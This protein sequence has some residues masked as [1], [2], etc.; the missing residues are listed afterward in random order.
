MSVLWGEQLSESDASYFQLQVIT[1][2]KPCSTHERC[3]TCTNGVCIGT[4]QCILSYTSKPPNIPKCASVYLHT[5]S[6]LLSRL[7]SALSNAQHPQSQGPW[8]YITAIAAW[9]YVY[10]TGLLDW[11]TGLNFWP[12]HLANSKIQWCLKLYSVFTEVLTKV[13]ISCSIQT[14]WLATTMAFQKWEILPWRTSCMRKINHFMGWQ[15]YLI[16]LCG[17]LIK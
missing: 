10:W 3:T 1:V 6:V 7:L 14:G 13:W 9:E 16:R 15:C 8:M 4:L 11:A 5:F 17:G 2:L 12:D